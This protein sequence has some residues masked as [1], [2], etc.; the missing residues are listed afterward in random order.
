MNLSHNRMNLSHNRM[1]LSHNRMNLSHNRMCLSNAL[2]QKAG[3]AFHRVI[4]SFFH[5]SL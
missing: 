2:S 4:T 1:N 5:Q 3:T